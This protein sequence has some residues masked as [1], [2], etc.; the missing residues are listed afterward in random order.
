MKPI[1]FFTA[2]LFQFATIA[3]TASVKFSPPLTNAT[4]ESVGMS[5]ERLERIDNMLKQAVSDADLPGIVALIA[6]NGKI[7]FQNAYGMA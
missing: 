2:L 3:Q 7:V 5:S 6:R 4:P 1:L